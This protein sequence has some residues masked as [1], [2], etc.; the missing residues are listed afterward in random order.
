MR[1]LAMADRMSAALDLLPTDE[2]VGRLLDAEER[3]VPAVRRAVPAI[4]RAAELI[5]DRMRDGG[6]LILLG[7]GTSGRLAVLQAAELPGTFGL[8]TD[9]VVGRTAG[10]G[11]GGLT[12]T[13]WD[14]DDTD[15][16]RRDLAEIGTTAADVLVAVAASGRTPYTVAAA[17]A[18]A[19]AGT[20]VVAVTTTSPS[21]LAALADVAV[22]VP[23]GLEVLRGSTRLTAGS[24][25]KITLDALTTAAMVRLGRVHGNVMIDVVAANAKLRDRS[26]GQV[27]EIV[28]CEL[29]SAREAL[30]R[31]GWYARAAVLHL[32]ADL[33][34]D[35]AI[36]LAAAHPTLRAAMAAAQVAGA[37]GGNHV[38]AGGSSAGV[39]GHRVDGHG[40]DGHRP[41][42]DG[43]RISPNGGQLRPDAGQVGVEAP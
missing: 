34:P 35:G 18:A 14:E 31:C 7:A 39:D 20:A 11:R 21:P 36:Q 16:G 38:G 41:G 3:V 6:R 5:A 29:G 8:P 22:E 25:Q 13:D 12:G 19:V 37:N 43:A 24:A 4:V 23:M 17:T 26:A 15:A 1:E 2:I 32:A 33:P 40:I 27:A 42:I 30:A 9:R 28:G 10:A